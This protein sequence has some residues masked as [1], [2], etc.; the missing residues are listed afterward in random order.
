M[1]TNEIRDRMFWTA[2]A[3]GV[4]VGL[5]G[6]SWRFAVGFFGAATIFM[7]IDDRIKER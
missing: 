4:V 7:V 5:R 2:L 6:S 1:K 3:F